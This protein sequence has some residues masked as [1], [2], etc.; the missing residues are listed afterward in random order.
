MF[1]VWESVHQLSQPCLTRAATE[2][3]ISSEGVVKD[4]NLRSID[5]FL[6]ED[7]E[8]AVLEGGVRP[9]Q[10]ESLYT[11][12]KWLTTSALQKSIRRGHSELA[13]RYARSSVRIDPDHA[14]RR[15]AIIALEDVGL[16]DLKLV[17]E[18][19]A[20]LGNK[21]RRR[22]LGEERLAVHLAV[23][24]S[25]AMKSRLACDL[26]SLIEYDNEASKKAE[27]VS[28]LDTVALSNF[29][30]RENFG[31]TTQLVSLWMLHG[32]DRLRSRQL[33]SIEGQGQRGLMRLMTNLSAPL[34]FH[35]IV[36][37]G[38]S[39]CRDSLALPYVLLAQF[40]DQ[41]PLLRTVRS[42][43][44]RP[45]LIG[46]YPSFAYDMHTRIGRRAIK[47]FEV[48]C[49][50]QLRALGVRDVG[51][52]IFALEGGCLDRRLSSVG[53]EPIRSSACALEVFGH[54]NS[55]NEDILFELNLLP[56]LD[57]IRRQAA[58]SV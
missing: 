43:I 25:S 46:S 33:N 28:C 41:N 14:F 45:E 49:T 22:S 54:E 19:L 10:H 21:L 39:R 38:L 40:A 24:M 47:K 29:V 5:T 35:Y 8:R 7:V 18:T 15:L 27:R 26:L 53:I 3:A 52:L 31:S 55:I 1:D 17:S 32:T 44:P 30:R 16:G 37:M 58:V 12:D 11:A 48:N 2:P 23:R 4:S 13:E 9:F 20:I 51:N 6:W 50:E 57:A 56:K 34:I 36:R 42:D